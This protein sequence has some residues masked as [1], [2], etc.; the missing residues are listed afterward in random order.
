MLKNNLRV[1]FILFL[2]KID[3]YSYVYYIKVKIEVDYSSLC[4]KKYCV[5]ILCIG[6]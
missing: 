5:W 6:Y 1:L 2:R 3:I 4:S